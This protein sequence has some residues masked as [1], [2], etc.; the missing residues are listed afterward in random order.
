M[1][2]FILD[3][4]V[5]HIRR[6][7]IRTLQRMNINIR[8]LNIRMSQPRGHGLD[9]TPV[10]EEQSRARMTQTVE[11]EVANA[12]TFEKVFELL[13]WRVR[14]H[15]MT[16]LLGENI[17]EIQPCVAEKGGVA[18]LL[19]HVGL[20]GLAE[21]FGDGD[22]ADAALGFRRLLQ[23]FAVPWLVD[24]PLDREATLLEVDV[25]PFE[26]HDL[27][28]PHTGEQSDLH[29]GAN[30]ERLGF[31]R[32]QD[33]ADLFGRV[34]LQLRLLGL[35]KLQSA[36]ETNVLAHVFHLVGLRQNGAQDGG[37][38][39][40]G[41]RAD[42]SRLAVGSRSVGTEKLNILLNMVGAQ[43]AELNRAEQRDELLADRSLVERE[44]VGGQDAFLDIQIRFA[45][46]RK[47]HFVGP[48]LESEA[49]DLFLEGLGED[50]DFSIELTE[51]QIGL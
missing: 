17:A 8:R 20:Q 21:A 51:G 24:A 19:L 22:G 12:V 9:V 33:L 7:P 44:C 28:A 23:G 48:F 3:H 1:I 40:D 47:A 4:T 36:R 13:G 25:L 43:V 10:G 27:A 5:E 50:F 29:H 46:S 26:S 35:R 15:D 32:Q 30:V 34:D 18:F 37:I 31:Q 6:L 14:I 11:L 16:V 42:V 39:F 2:S 38:A 49:G 45:E 41:G